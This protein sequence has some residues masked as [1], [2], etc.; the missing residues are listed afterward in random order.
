MNGI[1]ANEPFES[2]LEGSSGN[3]PPAPS[4]TGTNTKNSRE[5]CNAVDAADTRFVTLA[6]R[7]QANVLPVLAVAHSG[8]AA[9]NFSHTSSRL[10]PLNTGTV[11]ADPDSNIYIEVLVLRQYAM[12]E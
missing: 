4:K 6:V 3:T 10:D 9:T 12:I 8:T 5:E 11:A 1:R 2:I 7:R